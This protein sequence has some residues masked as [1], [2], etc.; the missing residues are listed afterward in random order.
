MRYIYGFH[1]AQMTKVTQI[2]PIWA[3]YGLATWGKG[4]RGRNGAEEKKK[5]RREKEERQEKDGFVQTAACRRRN[6]QFVP[7]FILSIYFVLS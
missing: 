3:P 5:G 7:R 6:F 2:I 4:K 1:L